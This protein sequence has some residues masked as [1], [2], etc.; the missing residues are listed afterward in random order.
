LAGWRARP[1]DSQRWHQLSAFG[2]RERWPVVR[3]PVAKRL[4]QRWSTMLTLVE[5]AMLL[6]R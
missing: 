6:A 5:I 1:H 2:L 4:G 3:T